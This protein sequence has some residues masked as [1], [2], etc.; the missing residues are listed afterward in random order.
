MANTSHHVAR[1]P[2]TRP[3]GMLDGPSYGARL[4]GSLEDA[5]GKHAVRSA[6]VPQSGALPIE[7]C[8]PKGRKSIRPG[9]KVKTGI[10]VG[11]IDPTITN[12]NRRPLTVRKLRAALAGIIR[13][14]AEPV[15]RAL[16]IA[17]S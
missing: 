17:R 7:L 16:E 1:R 5:M 8:P 14:Y 3:S 12:H 6:P 13:A 4:G 9:L 2:A 11:G 10:R 15:R